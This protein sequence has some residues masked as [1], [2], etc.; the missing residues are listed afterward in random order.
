MRTVSRLTLILA[1]LGGPFGC[2]PGAEARATNAALGG[3]LAYDLDQCI[4][5]HGSWSAYDQC[6]SALRAC[7]LAA[8]TVGEYTTC[9]DRV[10]R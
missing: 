1:L 10:A 5:K 3:L 2:V 9:A 8:K 6:E 4:E 7:A